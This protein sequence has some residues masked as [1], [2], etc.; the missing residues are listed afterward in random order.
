LSIPRVATVGLGVKNRSELADCLAAEARGP[1]TEQG[2]QLVMELRQKD[3][4]RASQ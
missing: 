2:L 3:A 4:V 1:L